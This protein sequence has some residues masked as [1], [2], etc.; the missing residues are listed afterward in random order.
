[1]K[2]Q[3][4]VPFNFETKNLAKSSIEVISYKMFYFQV[5]GSVMKMTLRVFRLISLKKTDPHLNIQ[6]P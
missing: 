6:Q 1:M 5:K 4:N 3:E 2:K